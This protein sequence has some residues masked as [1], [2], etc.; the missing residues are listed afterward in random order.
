MSIAVCIAINLI[1]LCALVFCLQCMRNKCIA[2][3]AIVWLI[4]FNIPIY[5]WSACEYVYALFDV[6]SLMLCFLSL[7]WF[8]AFVFARIASPQNTI[9]AHISHFVRSHQFFPP[10]IQYLWIGLGALLY[11]GFL[12]YGFIDIYHLEFKIQLCFL[13]IVSLFSY[14]LCP[15]AGYGL[16]LSILGYELGILGQMSIIN[17]CIDPFLWVCCIISL[18][19]RVGRA[20]VRLYYYGGRDGKKVV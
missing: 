17:Y 5:G 13:C 10:S 3:V 6:P 2:I 16:L 15:L 20:L 8:I 11:C 1:T 18:I 7:W 19:W 9:L 14:S 4:G 12:G